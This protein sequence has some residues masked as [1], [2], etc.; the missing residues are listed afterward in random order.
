MSDAAD[1]IIDR[2][3][4][5]LRDEIA[6]I[7]AGKLETVR[8]LYPDKVALMAELEAVTGRIEDRLSRG[9]DGAAALRERL[10]ELHV[11]IRKDHAL[12]ERMTEATGSVARELARIR[13]RHGLGG[14]YDNSG[15]TSKSG[16][17]APQQLDKSI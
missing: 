9:D 13:E 8:E 12:L 4:R 2:L 14:L 5:L 17:S 7:G 6:A 1:S 3:A 11:L 16:V 10:D 15:S